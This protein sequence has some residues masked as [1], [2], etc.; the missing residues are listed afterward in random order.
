MKLTKLLLGRMILA[1]ESTRSIVTTPILDQKDIEDSHGREP[2]RHPAISNVDKLSYRQPS[3]TLD[4]DRITQL[5]IEVGL[6]EV[7]R[8]KPRLVSCHISI[9]SCDNC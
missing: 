7:V 9:T 4:R 1:L 5:A 3:D 8:W 6:P 2:F